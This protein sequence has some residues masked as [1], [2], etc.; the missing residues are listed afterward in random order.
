M[1][2]NISVPLV[3]IV[4]TAVVGHLDDPRYLATVAFGA[5]T[6][7]LVLFL[8]GFLR[9]GTAGLVA[10]ASGAADTPTLGLVTLRALAIAIALGAFVAVL[11]PVIIELAIGFSGKASTLGDLTRDYLYP[12]LWFSAATL[13]NFVVLGVL[14]ALD[15]AGLALCVQLLLNGINI[16]LDVLFVNGFGWH[17]A[18]VAWASVVSETVACGVGLWVLSRELKRRG[19]VP[20][21]RALVTSPGWQR[22]FAVNRDIFIRS[23]CLVVSFYSLPLIGARMGE[24][25]LAAN[26]V[27]LNFFLLASYALDGFAHAAEVQAGTAYGARDRKLLRQRVRLGTRWAFATALAIT[28]CYALGGHHLIALMTDIESVRVSASTYLFWMVLAPLTGALAFQMDGVYFGTTHTVTLRNAM[29]Q[30]CALYA[31]LLLICVPIWQNHGLWFAFS[32]FMLSRGLILLWR[33]PSIERTIPTQR[34]H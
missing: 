3:G 14:I 34:V 6:V 10:Q 16:G 13:A 21:R 20:D 32:A 4:D 26:G 5:A 24:V 8:F 28:A 30:S 2:G 33:Y 7:S 9:M 23:A 1:L 31:V 17:V 18:G 12:R 25:V 22:L 27:L 11:S 29:L 19:A 15:R